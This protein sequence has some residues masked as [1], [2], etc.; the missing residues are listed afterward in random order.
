MQTRKKVPAHMTTQSSPLTLFYAWLLLLLF[1]AGFFGLIQ[2]FLLWKRARKW[3]GAATGTVVEIRKNYR[4]RG[5]FVKRWYE[6][7]VIAYKAR[8]V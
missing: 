6:Y 3:R 4:Y 2:E 1:L 7:P 5:L 8:C